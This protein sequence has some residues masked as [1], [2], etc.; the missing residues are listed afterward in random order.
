MA[1][2]ILLSAVQGHQH[3][4]HAVKSNEWP[5]NETAYQEPGFATEPAVQGDATHDPADKG[6]GKI[7]PENR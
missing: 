2:L 7:P 1:V 4:E 5:Q 3:L 6:G